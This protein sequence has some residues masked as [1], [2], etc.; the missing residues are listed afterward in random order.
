MEYWSVGVMIK[1]EAIGLDPEAESGLVIHLFFAYF[2][3]LAVKLI[4]N[5]ILHYSNTPSLQL[6]S[7]RSLT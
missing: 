5:P 3:F 2:A 1:P 6:E 7:L 4:R